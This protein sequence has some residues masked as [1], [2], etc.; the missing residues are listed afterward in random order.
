MTEPSRR[1][2]DRKIEGV[3]A[4]PRRAQGPTAD[5]LDER[6]QELQQSVEEVVEG[7]IQDPE[8]REKL[9]QG[10]LV[11]IK[12]ESFQSPYPPMSYLRELDVLVPGG[13][14]HLIDQADEQASHRRSLERS[15]VGGGERRANIGQWMGFIISLVVLT[16]AVL[17]IINGFGVEGTVLGSID[18]VALVTVFVTGK[19]SQERAARRP[20][21]PT[22]G[23]LPSDATAQTSESEPKGEDD[24]P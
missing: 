4:E 12:M 20:D 21:P 8:A 6:S 9:V 3:Q 7:I 24:A 16:A 2:V 5:D 10:V 22:G 1:G 11:A 19:G 23:P 15:V 14:K 18:L 17:L 13:A